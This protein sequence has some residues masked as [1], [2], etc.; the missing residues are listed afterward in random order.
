[1]IYSFLKQHINK[2]IIFQSYDCGIGQ[3]PELESHGGSSYCAIASLALMN[4]LN[5]LT[6]HQQHG[7]KRWLISR[8]EDGFQGRPNKPV[9]TCYSFWVGATLKIL[10]MYQFVNFEKNREYLLLTQD[11]LL[12]GLAKWVDTRADPLHTYMGLA[13]LSLM[14]GDGLNEVYPALNVTIRAHEHLKS[15]HKKWRN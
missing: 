9:D 1:M 5:R 12:G 14:G 2:S 6:P 3:G 13:G 8:Q 15:L 7:L 4:Q 10:D 11:A